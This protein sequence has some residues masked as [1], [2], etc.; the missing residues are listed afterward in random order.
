MAVTIL[1][2]LPTWYQRQ[3]LASIQNSH[4]GLLADMKHSVSM[5]NANQTDGSNEHQHLKEV[6]DLLDNTS[7]KLSASDQLPVV[8]GIEI[9]A[10]SMRSLFATLSS[11]FV[12]WL[13]LD[14]G[15]AAG[16]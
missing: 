9:E 16:G 3:K 6:I 5:L 1:C 15:I 11:M 2:T 10:W 7:E 14:S 13:Y 8:F 4:L 12:A